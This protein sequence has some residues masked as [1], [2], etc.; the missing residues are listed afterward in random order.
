MLIEKQMQ[1]TIWCWLL[2]LTGFTANVIAQQN[3]PSSFVKQD[4]WKGFNRVHF[5]VAGHDAYYVEPAKALSGKPWVW[6]ASFPNWHTEMDS[7]LLTKGFHVFFVNVDNQYGSPYAMQVWDKCYNY[8]T[9]S[10]LF[11]TK[12]ALEGVSRGGLY[13]YGWAK[14][15]PDKVSCIYNEAP[16]C[17]INSWPGGKGKGEGDK[18]SWT[19]CLSVLKLTEETA[20][21]YRDI[22]LNDLDGLASF[23]VPILH[24]VSNTDQIVPVAENTY[25]LVQRYT[26]LG[27]PA[28][29]F[30]VTSGPQE[31]K[32]HHFPIEKAEEWANFIV[33]NSWPIA[34][35]T[36]QDLY[37]MPRNGLNNVYRAITQRKTATVAFLGGS[38]TYNEGW[39]TKTCAY[40]KESFPETDFRFIKAGIPSLGSLPHVFRLSTDLPD[41]K[42]VD[43]LFVEAAVNDRVNGTDSLTQV[44]DLEGI[45]LQAKKANPAMDMVFLSFADPAKN[46]DYDL[47][48]QPAEVLNHE[49][50]AAYYGL[51]SINLAKLV[52]DQLAAKEYS[53]TYDFKDLHPSAF[54]QEIY[55]SAIKR[56]LSKCFNAINQGV[57]PERIPAKPLNGKSFAN[58]SY[59]SLEQAKLGKGWQHI[60]NWEPSDGLGTRPG[61]VKVPVLSAETAGAELSLSFNGT[62]VGLAVVAGGDAGIIE[63]SIDGQPYKAVDLFTQWSAK[64]H[65]PWYVLLNGDL[66]N[67]KHQLKL[68]TSANKNK[69]SKGNACRIVHFLVNQ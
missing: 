20:S 46:G 47:G 2:L 52:H 1:K 37:L 17:D 51:P 69:N 24:V 42:N 53:W 23:K 35:K 45:V 44:R 38:I 63:Y 10:L 26:A 15:N 50:V 65:L 19:Q 9:D 30:P 34:K 4:Q 60:A 29:V 33:S 7:L 28:S 11:A 32:G 25:P 36:N 31:L 61:F 54:G 39:R 3:R 5:K 64:L 58:A 16:V 41:L 8:L 62:A 43:L 27:G 40:L 13:V 6:R 22:P 48:K 66:P 56:L 67:K 18:A 49:K 68:R 55:F 12:P 14:R 21:A 59:Y 57:K